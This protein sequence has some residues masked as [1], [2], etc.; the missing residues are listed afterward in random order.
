MEAGIGLAL[1]GVVAALYVWYLQGARR[2]L[3]DRLLEH[4]GTTPESREQL[5][6]RTVRSFPPRYPYVPPSLGSIT[7]AA[8]WLVGLPLEVA[9]AAGVLV[10][11]ISYLAEEH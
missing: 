6:L 11:V 2:L 9:V 5:L 8:L 3:A 1:A 7:G 10:G 4:S